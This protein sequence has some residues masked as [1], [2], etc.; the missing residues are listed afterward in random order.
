M[1]SNPS[2]KLF[3]GEPVIFGGVSNER[4]LAE[5]CPNEF[6]KNNPWSSLASDLFFMGGKI[7]HWKFK[8]DNPVVYRH[9]LA[10]LRGLLGSFEISHEDKEAIAGWMLSEMLQEV[11]EYIER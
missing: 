2:E 10:C 9:Q 5:I 4:E 1:L 3:S 6:K 11:P 7:N 8:S